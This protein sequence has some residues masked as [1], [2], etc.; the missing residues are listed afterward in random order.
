MSSSEDEYDDTQDFL[1][2]FYGTP[3]Q[4]KYKPRTVITTVTDAVEPEPA[5]PVRVIKLKKPAAPPAPEPVPAAPV[6][7]IK[8]KKPTAPPAPE[9]VPEPVKEETKEQKLEKLSEA[10]LK[11]I[12][13]DYAAIIGY[14]PRGV[15]AVSKPKLIS[16]IINNNIPF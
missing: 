13:T 15:L 5:A 9:P 7:I 16:Y 8:L 10:D 12:L 4:R 6:R 2:A 1:N 14:I 11:K 3:R